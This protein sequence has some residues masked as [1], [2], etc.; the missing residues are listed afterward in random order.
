M[1][2]QDEMN[3]LILFKSDMGAFLRIYTFLSQI[4]DYANTAVEKRA[5]FYNAI[6][7]AC[8]AHGAMSRQAL[9]SER[10]RRGLQAILLGPGRLYESLRDPGPGLGAAP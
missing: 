4:F 3:A 1:A 7:D 6:I 8:A 9:D 5:I 2:A 10:V